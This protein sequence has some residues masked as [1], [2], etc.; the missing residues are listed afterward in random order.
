MIGQVGVA[1]RDHAHAVAAQPGQLRALGS[2]LLQRPCR[3]SSRERSSLRLVSENS[4]SNYASLDSSARSTFSGVMGRSVIWT[5]IA[6]VTA[7]AIA[8]IGGLAVISPTPFMP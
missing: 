2:V 4:F 5:P 7:L 8:G 6:S 3:N 1:L